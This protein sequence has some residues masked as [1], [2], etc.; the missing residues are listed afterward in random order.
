MAKAIKEM[1]LEGAIERQKAQEAAQD[2]TFDR[3]QERGGEGI[4]R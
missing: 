2:K 3:G 1:G 4:E